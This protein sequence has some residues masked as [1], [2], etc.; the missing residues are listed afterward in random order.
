MIPIPDVPVEVVFL[1]SDDKESNPA[2]VNQDPLPT[3]D[4]HLGHG[5]CFLVRDRIRPAA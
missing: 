5:V 1:R 2:E 3:D 4:Q